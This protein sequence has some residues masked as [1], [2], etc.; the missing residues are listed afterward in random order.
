MGS[1]SISSRGEA[2]PRPPRKADETIS[3]ASSSCAAHR[4]DE[5]AQK[6]KEEGVRL[7]PNGASNREM[8]AKHGER[9]PA[10]LCECGSAGHGSISV[11][12]HR[13]HRKATV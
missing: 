5:Q 8:D 10:D 13:S 12:I 6:G 9:G 7:P 3:R 1:P 11:G 4:L 2:C